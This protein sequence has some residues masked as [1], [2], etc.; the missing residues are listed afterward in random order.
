MVKVKLRTAFT[1]TAKE[2]AFERRRM[3]KTFKTR[4]EAKGFVKKLN[5]PAKKRTIFITDKFG[6]RKKKVIRLTSFRGG[7]S[8][9]GINNPRVKKIRTFI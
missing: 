9:A 1:V 2:N 8:G 5:K 4:K 6:K 3:I 7:I